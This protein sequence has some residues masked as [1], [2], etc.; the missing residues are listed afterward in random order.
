VEG[1]FDVV[2]GNP[3]YIRQ[4]WLAPFKPYWETR[5]RS[6]H[7]VADIF[8]YFFEQGI[9]L[10]RPG[11]RLAFITSGSWVRGNFGAPL[12]KVLATKARMESMVDFGEF[13][14]FEDAEMI[15]PSISILCKDTPGGEMRLFKWLTTGRPPETL[16]DEIVKAPTVRSE[17]FGEDAWELECDEALKL[18]AKLAA[19]HPTL[20][21]FTGGQILYG[22]KTGLNEVFVIDRQKRDELVTAD[23]RSA[24]VIRPIRQGSNIRPWYAEDIT[25]YLIFTRRGIRIEDYPAIHQYLSKFRTQLEPKPSNWDPRKKWPGRKEGSYLWFEIQDTVDY[26]EGFGRPKII[27]PD[28][29]NRPR[30]CSEKSGCLIGDTSFAIPVDD[31]F[32]L[33]VLSS[34]ATWFFI[35]KTAQPLRRRSDRWQYRLKAQYMEHIPSPDAPAAERQASGELARTCGALAQRRYQGQV[36]FQRRLF[37]AFASDGAGVLNQK[38]EAW[39]DQSLNTLG[40]ALKQ[41]FKLP[42]NPM[43][44]PRVADEWEPYLHKRTAENTRLTRA[45]AAAEAELNDRVYRLFALTPDEIRLL[46]KEV[47]H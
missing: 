12:R 45:L 17:R 11:G 41:S 35:S 5:F 4:E 22:I 16:S 23:A 33:G 29:T 21:K 2:V 7:G 31:D 19:G 44:N 18:R 34:W 13:Q 20:H 9:E 26:W 28:I 15:R 43:K 30:F 25:E 46:Q 14:P 10:M 40:D 24:E 1:G 8:T 38:A 39:W 32:L 42:A 36:H 27:W 3:P 47:E 6:Y 37:Q